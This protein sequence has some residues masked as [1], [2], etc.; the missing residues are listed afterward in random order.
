MLQNTESYRSTV[1][2]N[3]RAAPSP[4]GKLLGRM[5]PGTV[6]EKLDESADGAWIKFIYDGVEA[7]SSKRYLAKVPYIP[8]EGEDFPWMQFAKVEK[9]KGVREV[10]G[11][12][13]N[14]EVLK[15]LRSTT[16]LGK[17]A[18][19][20]DETPWCSAFVNWCLEQAGYDRTRNA[21]AR[22][23]LK[24]G[25]EIKT[26]RRGCIVVFEREKKFGHV[27]FYLEENE[28][29]IKVLGGNQQNPE[30]KIFEVSE[31]FY[32]KTD[33]LGYRIPK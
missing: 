5:T 8:P 9:A 16:N 20:K 25:Q 26:P 32:P 1:H 24:W 7:W 21:L 22:S 30:T 10:P 6:I 12:G 15:Y 31:K 2:L 23:W 4:S 17:A 11:S 29:H 14:P 3:V 19:S 13:N 28:T 33:L 27:G 18:I